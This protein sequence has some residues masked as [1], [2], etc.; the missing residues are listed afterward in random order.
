MKA[1]KTKK[2]KKTKKK[3]CEKYDHK[4]YLLTNSNCFF[5]NVPFIIKTKN[6]EISN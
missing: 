4:F 5:T 2:T 3:K 1:E 6:F